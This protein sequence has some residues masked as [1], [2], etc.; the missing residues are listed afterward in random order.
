MKKKI[1]MLLGIILVSSSFIAFAGTQYEGYNTTVGKF[2]GSGYSGYQTKAISGN[3]GWVLSKTV[4]TAAKD[5]EVDVRMID[6]DKNAGDWARNIGDADHSMLDASTEHK[7]GES[8]RL[9]F[10]NDLT[11]PK[12]I[13]VVGDWKSDNR[14]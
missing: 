14:Q 12:D 4:G 10:S 7:A 3:A 5:Y 2:N 13:Q 1:G 8:V 11:T 9:Q 6:V